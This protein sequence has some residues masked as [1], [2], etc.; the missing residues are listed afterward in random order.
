[1]KNNIKELSF[2]IGSSLILLLAPLFIFHMGDYVILIIYEEY[3]LYINIWYAILILLLFLRI[4]K[5]QVY[6]KTKI[7][8][9]LYIQVVIFVLITALP[10]FLVFFNDNTIDIKHQSVYIE[11]NDRYEYKVYDNEQISHISPEKRKYNRFIHK[12]MWDL[13]LTNTGAISINGNG[14]ILVN[15]DMHINSNL[16]SANDN[17]Y[18]QFVIQGN[19]YIGK[20]VTNIVWGFWVNENLYTWKSYKRLKMEEGSTYV[21]WKIFL[22]RE[23]IKPENK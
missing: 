23:N 1:M 5:N 22:E 4:Y 19:L 7:D 9:F 13:T 15:W 18:W 16:V 2:I 20:D 21:E 6:G 11:N 3:K 8:I 14:V 12:Y 10:V 17:S